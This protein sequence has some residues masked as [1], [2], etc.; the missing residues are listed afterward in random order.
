MSFI[1]NARGEMESV[2]QRL[3]EIDPFWQKCNPCSFCGYCCKGANPEFC[4]Q[5]VQE[6][7]NNCKY[8]EEE[9]QGLKRNLFW[10]KKCPF[11]FEDKC[12]IHKYRPLNCRWTPYQAAFNYSENNVYY[13]SMTNSCMSKIVKINKDKFDFKVFE[14]YY[15]WLPHF[16]GSNH[17]HILLNRLDFI[18]TYECKMYAT[19]VAK[20]ILKKQG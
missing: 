11:R 18:K 17:Y 13:S 8:T 16:D 14:K 7:I 10:S 5:E 19:D 4:N 6:I 9:I 12:L 3:Y 1:D 20:L 2:V 15:V